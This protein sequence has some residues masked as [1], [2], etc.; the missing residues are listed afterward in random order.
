MD[1]TKSLLIVCD[2]S[3]VDLEV[4]AHGGSQ[5]Y[6]QSQDNP[7]SLPLDKS[8]E[9]TMLL[10]LNADLTD[11]STGS[12]IMYAYLN[13]G[14]LQGWYMDS[15]KPYPLMVTPSSLS[16]GVLVDQR[17]QSQT[18]D[19]GQIDASMSTEESHSMKPV[20]SVFGQTT[21]STLGPSAVFEQKSP[22]TFMQPPAFGQPTS[23]FGQSPSQA[24]PAFGQ[25]SFGAFSGFNTKEIT[26]SGFGGSSNP[27]LSSSFGGYGSDPSAFGPSG[28]SSFEQG[29]SGNNVPSIAGAS[30]FP[31]RSSSITREASM[32]DST[33]SFGG[34]SLG[35]TESVSN[36]KPGGGIFGSFSTH[37][38]SQ[39]GAQPASG[40]GGP[41]KPAVG[42]GAFSKLQSTNNPNTEKPAEPISAF[43]ALSSDGSSPALIKQSCFG[44][45]GFGQSG[46]GQSGFGQSGFGQVSKPALSSAS[47]ITGRGFSAFASA[48]PAAFSGAPQKGT[49]SGSGGAFAPSSAGGGF[50]AFASN[51]PAAFGEA[52]KIAAS[53]SAS[54]TEKLISP[55]GSSTSAFGASTS[56]SGNTFTTPIASNSQVAASVVL[57]SPTKAPVS[58]PDLSPEPSANDRPSFA[59]DDSPPPPLAFKSSTPAAISG[60][61]ANIKTSPAAF[62]PASGFGAFGSDSTSKTSPFFKNPGETK[63]APVSVFSNFS[64]ATNPSIGP[65]GPSGSAPTFGSPSLIG[66]ANKSAFAPATPPSPSP[67]KTIESGGFGAFS[68]T[69]SGFGVFAGPKKSFSDLLKI[70]DNDVQDAARPQEATAVF[71]T[72]GI[73][74]SSSNISSSLADS[75]KTKDTVAPPITPAF[76]SPAISKDNIKQDIPENA[77]ETG[78]MD[79]SEMNTVEDAKKT[80]GSSETVSEEPSLGSISSAGSSFVEV[81]ADTSGGEMTSR[82][83]SVEEYV[84]D[85]DDDRSFL[86][87]SFGSSSDGSYEDDED[88]ERQ[89]SESEGSEHSPSPVPT[90]VPLPESRSPSATPQPEVPAI[91]VTL[92]PHT[93]HR[94]GPASRNA[95]APSTTPPGTPVKESRPLSSSSP[96]SSTAVS[97]TPLQTPFGLGLGKPS[98]RPTRSSP[99]ASAP[100]S[101][102]DDDEQTTPKPPVSPKPVF[103]VLHVSSDQLPVDS[104]S[105]GQPSIKRSKTPPLLSSL[106]SIKATPIS[107]E[108]ILAAATLPVTIAPVLT[109]VVPSATPAISPLVL[110][111]PS[112]FERPRPPAGQDGT[113]RPASTPAFYGSS[114]S[115]TSSAS[116]FSLP[117]SKG[118]N[119]SA[120]TPQSAL[121][122]QS[123]PQEAFSHPVLPAP[124][125]LDNIFGAKVPPETQVPHMKPLSTNMISTQGPTQLGQGLF[126]AQASSQTPGLFAQKA[127]VT[128]SS[129]PTPFTPHKPPVQSDV[130]KMEEGMQKECALLVNTVHKELEEVSIHVQTL[131]IG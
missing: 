109:P 31:S 50:S 9:D 28:T 114:S 129:L 14:T 49:E 23:A 63:P 123:A 92:P 99:L 84:Q 59:L 6:Q 122:S 119:M 13:D 40:F 64:T 85:G 5:W 93:L 22:S 108:P 10:A 76:A 38:A 67:A 61:F 91:E 21:T 127:P 89:G 47:S 35:S 131:R 86:S 62:R 7:I 43:G 97:S 74:G 71:R 82:G 52:A 37:P 90:T 105:D 17:S 96:A 65:G 46:F 51:T 26:G 66:G 4:V 107:D 27:N 80:S 16:A 60:A 44:Q 25:T 100:M 54:S 30:G 45:S 125:K 75:N 41:V 2:R 34:L 101:G 57:S 36:A 117:A 124:S 19:F 42:F 102:N 3:S 87:E 56:G 113:V 79:G 118:F 98:T 32:S 78:A 103:G 94:D 112:L 58:S 95:R 110:S 88:S 55:F 15:S 126:P 33:P 69:T 128:A 18:S 104:S 24:S 81:S 121:S 48:A 70:G 1:D 77:A 115:V 20:A 106:G 53:S 130:A 11:S 83:E 12:P 120:F 116:P 29:S 72:P 111:S 68:G 73:L 8:M 39:S